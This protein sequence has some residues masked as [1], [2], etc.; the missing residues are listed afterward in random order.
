M[1]RGRGAAFALAA[2][3]VVLFAVAIPLG[4]AAHQNIATNVASGTPLIVAFL[5][6]GLV[7]AARQ[8]RHPIGWMLL[9]IAFFFILNVDASAYSVTAYREHRGWP[10]GWLAVILQPSWA[11]AIVLF[12][13]VV[14]LFPDGELPSRRWRWP[15][16]AYLLL[17]LVWAGGAFGIAV[18]AVVERSVGMTT[19]GDLNVINHPRGDTAWWGAVQS[20]FFPLLGLLLLA[21]LAYQVPRYRRSGPE[22]RQQLKWLIGGGAIATIGGVVTVAEVN[23]VV[24]A[25]ALTCVIA[26]PI[27]LGIGILKFRL[28]EID[29]IIRKTIVYAALVGSLALVYLGGIF[30][31]GH[32]LEALTGQSGPLAVTISTLAVAGAF[33]PLRRR[34]QAT[35][36]TTFYRQNYDAG[37]TLDAFTG[38][39]REQIDLDSLHADLVAVIQSTVQPRHIEVWLRPSKQTPS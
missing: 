4:Q 28:Y 25:V 26:L 38:R 7:V 8:P 30:L 24:S 6:V 16:A 35:V 5:A 21:W 27:S 34:I 18:R 3:V 12:G 15:A 1:R 39:L 14:L 17:G 37:Q 29:V 22:R 19:G 11:P 13:L 23:G 10:L 33:Q 32:S 31:I 36:A 20:S 9:L 2:L